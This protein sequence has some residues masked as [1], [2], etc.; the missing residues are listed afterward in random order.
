MSDS[1]QPVTGTPKP[2]WTSKT[3]IAN[4]IIAVLGLA[5]YILQGI[6]TGQLQPPWVIEPQ[7]LSFWYG[8]LGMI[9]RFVTTQPV[10][11]GNP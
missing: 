8:V 7:T 3:I 1:Q 10:T 4:I 11:G 9:L 6:Q 5:M 2:W